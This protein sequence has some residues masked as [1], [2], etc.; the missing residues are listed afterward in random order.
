MR[1][2]FN[3]YKDQILEQSNYVFHVVIPVFIP[4]QDGYFKESF[5]VLKLCLQSL[6]KTCS[7]PTKIT[8]VDNGS[9]SE[10]SKYL[11][12]LAFENQIQ[13]LLQTENIGKLNAILK[14]ISGNKIPLVTISDSDVLFLSNWQQ[15]TV[16][17]LNAFHKAAVVGLTPQFK[18]YES[19]PNVIFDAF[20]S[21]KLQFRKP[22]NPDA[23][24]KFYD[25][26]GW[27][28]NYNQDYLKYAL[29]I[30]NNKGSACIGSGH[31]V[32]TYRNGLF[33]T[34]PSYFNAKMGASSES[35]LDEI[36]AFHNA[37]K[38]TTSDNF[39]YHIGNTPENWMH[40]IAFSTTEKFFELD[41]SKELNKISNWKFALKNKVFKKIFKSNFVR[42]YFYK[43]KGLPK[44]VAQNY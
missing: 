43:I 26:I 29:T 7:Y 19:C 25:S 39:A 1:Q 3:P 22:K 4:N 9:C 40:E 5:S 15:E 41:N 35:F 38:L 11:Q 23:I 2:G 28:H 13:D 6:F 37:W 21:K 31:F 32:A 20:F 10:V 12:N 18:M 8:I 33:E 14:G 30:E 42:R 24:Y 27:E 16:K 34:L 44:N 36:A 17:V